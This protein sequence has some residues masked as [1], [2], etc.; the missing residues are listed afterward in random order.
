MLLVISLS[1]KS[2]ATFIAVLPSLLGEN[3]ALVTAVI[4][5][6]LPQDFLPSIREQASCFLHLS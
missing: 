2:T 1:I 5:I 6:A 4:S 3:D